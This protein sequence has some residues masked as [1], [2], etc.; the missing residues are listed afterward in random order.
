M[1]GGIIT[2]MAKASRVNRKLPIGFQWMSMP[3]WSPV[4]GSVLKV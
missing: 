2:A 4:S 3:D 1:W